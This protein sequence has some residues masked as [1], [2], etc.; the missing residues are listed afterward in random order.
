MDSAV[1]VHRDP[2]EAGA[3]FPLSSPQRGMWLAQRMTPGVPVCI[4][5]YVELHGPLDLELLAEASLTAGREFQSTFSRIVEVDGEPFQVVDP[6]LGLSTGFVDFRGT[7]DPAAAAHAWM[8]RDYTSPIDPTRDLLARSAVLQIGEQDYLCYSRIHHIALD[9][10]GATTLVNRVAELYTATVEGRSPEP[11]QAADLRTLYAIDQHYRS[12][13]RFESDHA[14]WMQRVAEFGEGSSLSPVVAPAVAKSTLAGGFLSDRAVGRLEHSDEVFGVPAATMVVAALGCYLARMT[15]QER[16]LV[17]LPVSGRTTAV[18]RR[19]GG[20]LAT[21]AP[22]QVSEQPGDTLAAVLQR[23]QL[24]V[25]GA[26]RHQRYTLDDIRRETGDRKSTLLLA[27][28]MVN[29]MLFHPKIVLGDMTGE[30]HVVTS[31]PVDDLLVNVYRSGTPEKTVVEFRG[32]PGRYTDEGLRAHHR[33]FVALL[34]DFLAGDTEDR[35]GDLHAETAAEG[36]RLRRKTAR[37]DYWRTT[38]D[39]LSA[40]RLLRTDRPVPPHAGLPHDGCITL[41]LPA[42]L[43]QRIRTLG[44]DYSFGGD[45]AFAGL[46]VVHTAL[47]A[48]LARLSA[49]DDI[50]IGATVAVPHRWPVILRTRVDAAC[51]FAELLAH[52]RATESAAFADAEVPFDEVAEVLDLPHPPTG[53]Y[54]FEVVLE[55]ADARDRTAM[56]DPDLRVRYTE[57]PD[58]T[59]LEMTFATALVEPGTIQ[60]FA[61]RLARLLADATLRPDVPVGDLEVFAPTE[62]SGLVPAQGGP[63]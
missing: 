12:S 42:E 31:G 32:N 55:F 9:G 8:E 13:P 26:L 34:E 24:E 47:I 46:S 41:R 7:P 4:A 33:A 18:L 11:S 51:S 45:C 22:L 37:L 57:H 23:V 5:Q 39:G 49:T 3:A 21:V 29:V 60:M 52:A 36:A 62:L 56:C 58:G 44:G 27:G 19:S 54:P 14:Y 1:S 59:D 6:S 40:H 20:M 38:L 2:D 10:Y 61:D 35:I 16:V 15:G 25:M 48:L 50:A 43:H 30:F 17:N 53:P 28:P 63:A